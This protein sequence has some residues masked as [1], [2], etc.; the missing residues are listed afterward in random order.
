MPEDNDCLNTGMIHKYN[1]TFIQFSNT[2][3]LQVKNNCSIKNN[4]MKIKL[5]FLIVAMM[6][7]HKLDNTT[8]FS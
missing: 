1:T 4:R 7:V 2:Y 8:C 5:C 6:T 3:L